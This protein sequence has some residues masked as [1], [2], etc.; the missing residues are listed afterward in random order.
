MCPICKDDY[1]PVCGTD[2]ITYASECYLKQAACTSKRQLD[3]AKFSACGKNV[4]KCLT[5]EL[6]QM[7]KTT[8]LRVFHIMNIATNN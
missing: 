8:V 2:G 4:L 6:I 1:S 3:V 7:I 5:N